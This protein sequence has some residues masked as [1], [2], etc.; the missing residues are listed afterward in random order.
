M[1]RPVLLA[2]GPWKEALGWHRLKVT[3][4]VSAAAKRAGLLG[5]AKVEHSQS[6]LVCGICAIAR[7]KVGAHERELTVIFPCEDRPF[8]APLVKNRLVPVFYLN[9]L[10]SWRLGCG[11]HCGP[12][13]VG[14]TLTPDF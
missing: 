2:D 10:K 4:P 6:L 9:V 13:R 12:R 7:G 5:P 14:L 8:E 11:F 1:F 3:G